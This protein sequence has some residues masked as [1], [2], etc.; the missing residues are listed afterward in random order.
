RLPELSL[1]EQI[2]HLLVIGVD[3]DSEACRE[4][5][6]QAKVVVACALRLH[7]RGHRY[8]RRIG[9]SLVEV[10]AL[11]RGELLRRRGEVAG[12]AGVQRRLRG[13]FVEGVDARAP[14][15]LIGKRRHEIEANAIVDGELRYWPP[16]VLGVESQQVAVLAR[17]V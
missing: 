1:V 3:P 7:G 2:G 6:A 16:L 10:D 8:R 12:E 4:L 9:R 15:V 5:L 13:D 11:L 14:L 17:V